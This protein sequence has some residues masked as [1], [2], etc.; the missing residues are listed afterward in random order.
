[1]A[2][3]INGDMDRSGPRLLLG[4]KNNKS[5]VNN[6][7]NNNNGKTVLLAY[8]GKTAVFPHYY[9]LYQRRRLVLV[10]LHRSL[11]SS[12]STISG[13]LFVDDKGCFSRKSKSCTRRGAALLLSFLFCGSASRRSRRRRNL[14]HGFSGP[15]KCI[16]ICD[17][18]IEACDT[19]RR[20]SSR[21]LQR[22]GLDIR[23]NWIEYRI[24]CRKFGCTPTHKACMPLVFFI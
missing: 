10:V 18:S 13:A 14:D 8:N 22:V 20:A 5:L 12:C 21:V 4:N 24:D 19:G 16:E 23:I 1:M 2:A 3:A 9:V 15:I 7:N 6:N 17:K 11:P